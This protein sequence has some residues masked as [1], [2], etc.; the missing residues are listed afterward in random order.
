MNTR[1]TAQDLADLRINDRQPKII[2]TY[3]KPSAS[4]KRRPRDSQR[5][6]VYAWERR[7][8]LVGNSHPKISLEEC[9]ALVEKLWV[10]YMGSSKNMP[11]VTDGRGRRSACY[12]PS[13]NSLRLPVWS[14]Q[15]GVVA[16]EV[17]HAIVDWKIVR[18]WNQNRKHAAH[19]PEFVR[20]FCELAVAFQG[21]DPKVLLEGLTSGKR[22]V[23][24]SA[25]CELPWRRS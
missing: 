4:P 10:G 11:T 14:R 9:R 5:S 13:D 8:G 19:G 25:P 1:I 2:R 3:Y 20:V 15:E 16:H 12:S 17:A 18:A 6:A 22:N 21:W 7:V 23:R 24:I